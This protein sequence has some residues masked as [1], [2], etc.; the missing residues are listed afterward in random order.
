M[1]NFLDAI[2]KQIAAQQQEQAAAAAR[3]AEAAAAREAALRL[4][5]L[6][7]AKIV[8]ADTGAVIVECQFNPTQL[9][10]DKS[11]KWTVAEEASKNVGK[12][13]FGGGGSFNLSMDLFFDTT[14]NQ[15]DV[16]TVY[17]NKL[18]DLVTYRGGPPP[19][20]K[21]IWGRLMSFN[22][23]VTKVSQTYNLFLQDGTPVRATVKVSFQQANNEVIA[24]QNPTSRTPPR[25]V[26]VV[27]AGETLDWIAYREYG[28]AEAW[29]H[30]AETNHLANP[31]DLRP[32]QVL[33][34]LPL[35]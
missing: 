5:A 3:A 21:F 13:T 7:K 14:H 18:L 10:L 1:F 17:V 30:I 34:L 25:K 23:Y 31:R 33:T 16:R 15:Q 32:G 12:V 24:P 6:G 8:N 29:R 4:A 9:A 28:D 20:V 22:A 26:W 35:E 11:N 19:R 2:Q 27:T